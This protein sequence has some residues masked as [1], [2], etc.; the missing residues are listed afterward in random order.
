MNVDGLILRSQVGRNGP[1]L[2][3]DVL[4]ALVHERQRQILHEAQG[5][6]FGNSPRLRHHSARDRATSLSHFSMPAWRS[7][8]AG[9]HLARPQTVECCTCS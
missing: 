1:V 4:D 9:L 8:A 3:S 6:S 2:P 5:S 7:L